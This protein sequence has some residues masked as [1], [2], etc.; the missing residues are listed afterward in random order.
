M[1]IVTVGA[2]LLLGLTFTIF[3]ANGFL[4]AA[5]ERRAFAPLPGSR[6]LAV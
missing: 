6:S 5:S 4:V 2:R 3:G 1:R